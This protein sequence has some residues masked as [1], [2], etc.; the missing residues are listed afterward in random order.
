MK[1]VLKG[2]LCML[3]VCFFLIPVTSHAA[4]NTSEMAQF[5][6]VT[7]SPDG[8]ARAWTTDLWD[9]TNERLPWEYTV[10]MNKESSIENLGE[11]EHYYGKQAEGSVTIG[12][13]VVMHT[14]G[15]CIHPSSILRGSGVI[16][17]KTTSLCAANT[18]SGLSASI[19]MG[20]T[21]FSASSM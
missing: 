6:N 13:W 4:A 5:P 17:G 16:S 11:G 9:K 8:T 12:K 3:A 20:Y 18:S 7:L 19:P 21:T 10:D 1:K 15:Q 2:F 14:P